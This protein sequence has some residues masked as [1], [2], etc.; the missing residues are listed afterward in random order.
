MTSQYWTHI[1]IS[2]IVNNLLFDFNLP[3]KMNN[4]MRNVFLMHSYV[5]SC[6]LFIGNDIIRGNT[7]IIFVKSQY[8]LA[9]NV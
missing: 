2:I 5:I 4:I 8:R 7:F 9:K 6:C 1:I 3:I